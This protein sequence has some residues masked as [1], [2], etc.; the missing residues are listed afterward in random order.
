ML[1]PTKIIIHCSYSTFGT[2]RV[3]R[4]WHTNP[5]PEGN[6]WSDIGYHF[7]IQNKR[8]TMS[9]DAMPF[10]D[11][12]ITPGRPLSRIGAHCRGQNSNSIGICLIGTDLFSD[13]QFHSLAKLI[14]GLRKYYDKP[15]P[16]YG[17]NHFNKSKTCPNFDLTAFVLKYMLKETTSKTALTLKDLEDRVISIEEA[18]DR[19]GVDL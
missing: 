10:L 9:L 12:E 3:I 2:E 13:A 15:L 4:K 17:H 8:P 6:G 1:K 14:K 7:I 11:G 16:M 5:K 18:L 19:V